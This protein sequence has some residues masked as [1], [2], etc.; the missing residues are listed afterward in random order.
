MW[1]VGGGLRKPFYGTLQKEVIMYLWSNPNIPNWQRLL[2]GAFYLPILFWWWLVGN[3]IFLGS[4][5]TPHAPDGAFACANCGYLATDKVC[6][7]CGFPKRP[8][9]NV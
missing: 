6:T 3:P 8:A 5:R 4:R 1:V 7:G 9:G 2:L